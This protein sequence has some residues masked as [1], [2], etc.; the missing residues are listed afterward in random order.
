MII[1]GALDN[2]AIGFMVIYRVPGIWWGVA[3]DCKGKNSNQ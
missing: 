3:I 1:E 2:T